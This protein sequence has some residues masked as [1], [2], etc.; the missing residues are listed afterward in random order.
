MRKDAGLSY[1]DRERNRKWGEGQLNKEGD[2]FFKGILAAWCE[3]FLRSAI[4]AWAARAR[5]LGLSLMW[6]VYLLPKWTWILTLPAFLL[7][8]QM[9]LQAPL[10]RSPTSC[11]L[12]NNWIA[13]ADS[14]NLVMLFWRKLY[15][16]SSFVNLGILLQGK[17]DS[18]S[19]FNVYKLHW[20]W[21]LIL[22]FRSNLFTKLY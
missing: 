18:E 8:I 20:A 9:E 17:E 6:R 21:L 11:T 2:Y 3:C 7:W 14:D 12:K 19:Q 10:T 16:L 4:R 13:W 1:R 5:G 22:S 15:C